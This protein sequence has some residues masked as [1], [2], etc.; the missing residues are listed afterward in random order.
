MKT[1]VEKTND[2]IKA[3]WE[4]YQEAN[5]KECPKCK[6]SN[7]K[8][9]DLYYDEWDL[10]VIREVMCLDCQFNWEEIFTMTSIDHYPMDE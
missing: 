8:A 6:S 1:E 4:A 7:I 3:R 5:G 2:E 9:D 10:E